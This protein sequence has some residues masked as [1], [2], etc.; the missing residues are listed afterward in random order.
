MPTPDPSCSVSL[1]CA[2]LGLLCTWNCT[3]MLWSAVHSCA[4]HVPCYTRGTTGKLINCGDA[5]RIG[6]SHIRGLRG[7]V[8]PAHTRRAPGIQINVPA[9][10]PNALP[11]NITPSSS[12]GYLTRAVSGAHVWAAW[13]HQPCL[14]GGLQHRDKKMGKRGETL[15]GAPGALTYSLRRSHRVRNPGGTSDSLLL[16]SV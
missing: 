15:P 2:P 12:P 9:I 7:Y 3:A 4:W 5:R 1:L 14:F 6:H 13:L 11:P 8:C 10:Y 16:H